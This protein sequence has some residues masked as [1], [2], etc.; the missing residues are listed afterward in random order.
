MQVK[1]YKQLQIYENEHCQREYRFISCI[2]KI[3][4]YSNDF[5]HMLNIML[6][7]L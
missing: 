1:S 7:V 3:M 2:F 5:V 6:K 4:V